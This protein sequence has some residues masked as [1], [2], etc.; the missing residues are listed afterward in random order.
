LRFG[1]TLLAFFF[2][3]SKLSHFKEDLKASIDDRAKK[4]G[5]RDWIQ[6]G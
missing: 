4:G 5:Y 3:S 6:V 2:T 1:T